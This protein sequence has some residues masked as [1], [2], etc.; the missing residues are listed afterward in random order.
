MKL[1]VQIALSSLI[2]LK[3][4]AGSI[5]LCQMELVPLSIEGSA[6]ASEPPKNSAGTEVKGVAV[7]VEGKLDRNFLVE[8]RR[9]L[10][11]K[12][13]DLKMKREELLALQKQIDER[14]ALLSR[15]REQIRADMAKKRAAKEANLKHLIKVYSSMKPQKAASLIE[16]LDIKFAVRL[17]GRMKGDTVGKILSFVD[18]EKAAKISE[19]LVKQQ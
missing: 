2:I 14:I 8:K 1:I 12:E 13:Q 6:R 10:E 19:G 15:L 3:I 16:K 7:P 9:E 17:L 5:F 4:V 18:T 11:R